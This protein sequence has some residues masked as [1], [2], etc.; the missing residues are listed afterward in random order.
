VYEAMTHLYLIRH[1]QSDGLQEGINGTLIPNAGLSATGIKQ[2]ERL[3]ER[4]ASTADIKADVL[5]SS[6]LQRARETA[7]IIAPAWGLEVLEDEDLQEINLAEAEGLTDEQ[8][9]ERFGLFHLEREPFRCIARSG[10]SLSDFHLRTCRALDRILRMYTDQSIVVVCHGGTINASFIYF[11]GLTL[12]KY[13]PIILPTRNTAITHWYRAPF[14]GYGRSEPQ[15]F[16][17]RF[18]D[19]HHLEENL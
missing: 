10:E 4:L 6:P 14:E 12:L 15:W 3:R 19:A 7:Q 18:N 8:I 1:A 2:A 11:L 9:R 16:L 17:E 13:P 5:L